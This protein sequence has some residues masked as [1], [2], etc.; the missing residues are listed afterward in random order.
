MIKRSEPLRNGERW[1][2]TLND[3]HLRVK[4][5]GVYGVKYRR[6]YPKSGLLHQSL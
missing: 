5:Q 1:R 2:N 4:V 6:G 3:K